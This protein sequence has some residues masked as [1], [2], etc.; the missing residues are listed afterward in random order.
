MRAWAP[1]V[2]ALSLAAAAGGGEAADKRALTRELW[3]PERIEAALE[4]IQQQREAGLLTER[5][6]A[7]R[8]KMLEARKAGTYVSESLSVTN[9]PLN[10]IQNG[11]F[12]K[13]N[14]NTRR[15]RSRWLWWG[16]WSWGGDYENHWEERPKHVH[17]GKRSARIQCVGDRGR[18][19][20]M[21]PG[22]P[23][24]PDAEAYALTF[25]AKGTGD[26]QLFVNF[27][28]G[29]RGTLRQR[30]GPEW[31]QYSLA[32]EPVA[33]KEEY[34][35]YFYATGKGTLWL[36]DVKLVPKGGQTDF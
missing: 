30:I 14:R 12:E 6:Y 35:V 28:V 33:G 3:A 13:I 26:N 20:I 21:T 34:R 23:A 24:V 15:N 9:P 31:K 22:L 11:G 7:K 18:I 32:G 16:G 2:W 27:E 5:A 19:G 1:L 4:A 8:R 25:W 17:S 36:D 29:A 10:F